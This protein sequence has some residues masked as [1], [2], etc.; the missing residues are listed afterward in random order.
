MPTATPIT[1]QTVGRTFIV[2][3]SILGIGALF[4]LAMICWAFI[5]RYHATSNI[6]AEIIENLDPADIPTLARL[7]PAQPAPDFAADPLADPPGATVTA[8]TNGVLPKPTPI[9]AQPPKPMDPTTADRFAE[10]LEQG[11]M[12]RERGDTGAALTKFREAQALE[13]R[14]P[15]ALAEI[16][17]TYE[18]MGLADRANEQWKRVYDLG[19]PAGVLY[20]AAEA[21]LK[22]AQA[23]EL[24]RVMSQGSAVQEEAAS[25]GIAR[26]VQLGLAEVKLDEIRDP[27]A[28]KKFV[29]HVPIKARYGT[30]IDASLLDIQVRFFDVVDSAR[31]ETTGA[32]VS[33]RWGAPPPDWAEGETE[34]LQVNYELPAE[35]RNRKYFG[36]LVRVYYKGE[37]QSAAGTP[38]SLVQKYPP[39]QTLQNEPNQ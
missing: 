9:V 18:K 36:Y 28:S 17:M 6:P 20:A 32:N 37:L 30:K 13:A 15:R 25:S 38:E 31:V 26:G 10:L 3:I 21:K 5:A 19:E 23:N 7:A 12:L 16:A 14:N 35:K 39:P 8:R 29:L 22:A 27:G 11:K 4:Q 33:S 2:A 1:R 34:E 24:S